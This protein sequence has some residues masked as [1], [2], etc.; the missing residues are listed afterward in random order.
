MKGNVVVWT[1]TQSHLTGTTTNTGPTIDLFASGAMAGG[2]N[3]G[4]QEFGI[5]V[6]I[7][8][9]WVSGTAQVTTWEWET[10]P[11]NSTWFKGGFIRNSALIAAG[12]EKTK[13]TLRTRHRYARL[14]ASNAGTGASTSVAYSEDMGGLSTIAPSYA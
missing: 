3:D 10:S 2:V 7:I 8:Q 11:D 1:N 14:L 6:Q 4:T 5:G 13:T 9:T 12:N